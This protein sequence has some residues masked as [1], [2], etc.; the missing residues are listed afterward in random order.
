MKRICITVSSPMTICAFLANHIRL[1]GQF[2]DVS[3]IANFDRN[4]PLKGVTGA[5]HLCDV[6]IERK[7]DIIRDIKAL[8]ALF[9]HFSHYRYDIVHSVTPKAGLL[10]MAAA[11]LA[12]VPVRIHTFTGQV[13]VT[14]TGFKR[15][16]LKSMD[17]LLAGMA[18]HILVDSASQRTFLINEGVVPPLKSTV[19][20]KGSISGVDT[21]R[22]SPDSDVRSDVRSELGVVEGDV[23]FLFLGRLNRDKGV[24]DLA[25]AFASIAGQR[26]DT[27][28]LLVGPDE[29]GMRHKIERECSRFLDRV[30]FI[31]YTSTPEKFMV[32]A[33]VFCLPSYREG[34]GTVVIESA[35]SGIPAIGSNIYGISDAIEDGRSGLLFEVGNIVM[36]SDKMFELICDKE[37]RIRMGKYARER[38]IS[39]FQ[40]DMLSI[41]LMQYYKS[42]LYS[43]G[44]KADG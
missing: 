2:F 28:L 39:H 7:I 26:S 20:A 11:R 31:P 29:E 24:L 36:L 43:A 32:A 4:I 9:R 44:R 13:W 16:L 5:R 37:V 34:F 8:I 33:D 19:L 27:W 21:V 15:M 10:A 22:F 35:S 3:V 14:Q 41:E 23:V 17:R 6:T 30:R 38:A 12:G 18:T 1:L 25:A 42:V 40:S